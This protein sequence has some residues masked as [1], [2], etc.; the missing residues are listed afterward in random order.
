MVVR[1]SA[2]RGAG[3]GS[4]AAAVLVASAL[5]ACDETDPV[6][7]VG[8]DEFGAGAGGG[9]RCCRPGGRRPEP[10]GRG[11]SP[12][13]GAVER[14]FAGASSGAGRFFARRFVGCWTGAGRGSGVGG[15]GRREVFWAGSGGGRVDIGDLAD[16]RASRWPADGAAQ[17]PSGPP[18]RPGPGLAA[19][20]SAA[21]RRWRRFGVAVGVGAGPVVGGQRRSGRPG[22]GADRRHGDRNPGEPAHSRRGV[23]VESSGRAGLGGGGQRVD[24]GFRERAAGRSRVARD[25]A[26]W[27]GR[28]VGVPAGAGAAGL[29]PGRGEPAGRGQRRGGPAPTHSFNSVNQLSSDGAGYDADGNQTGPAPL[30]SGSYNSADQTTSFTPN[31]QGQIGASYAGNGQAQRLTLGNTSY[32][33]GIPGLTAETTGAASTYYERDPAGT[34]IAQR[35]NTG[36]F[37]YYLDGLGSVLGLIDTSGTV[38]AT[39]SY[40]PYGVTTAV[41][42]PNSNLA[43]TNP[44]RYASGYFDT[45]TGLYQYGQRYYQPSLGRWTQQDTLN[46]IGD[47][48]NGN[49]YTYTGDDPVNN[50]DPTGMCDGFFGCASAAASA[51]GNALSS[52]GSTAGCVRQNRRGQARHPE[53][54]YRRG[55]PQR[56]RP[57]R[58]RPGPRHHRRPARPRHRQDR[59]HPQPHPDVAGRWVRPLASDRTHPKG[60]PA[61]GSASENAGFRKLGPGLIFSRLA[62]SVPAGLL[63]PPGDD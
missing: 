3:S 2:R 59:P 61:R 15:A 10:G 26:G 47:P 9:G 17:Y 31:G 19:A 14:P 22:V 7:S 24:R 33:N 30:T 13:R 42:G 38:Q 32:A 11:G 27:R 39:Y 29:L 28:G 20:G 54:P 55:N 51:V 5:E 1:W 36:E 12:R 50:V 44:Y 35:G 49:R 23:G 18:A 56:A 4:A 25:V 60:L 37:Y 58:P 21:D 48:A 52:A 8:G 63:G 53:S 16:H 43:N 34:L 40:D 46:M 57:A 41:G 45:A 6:N 62:S